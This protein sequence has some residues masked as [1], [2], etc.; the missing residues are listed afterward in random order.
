MRAGSGCYA[1]TSRTGCGAGSPQ[2]ASGLLHAD[3]QG[4]AAGRPRSSFAVPCSRA[5]TRAMPVWRSTGRITDYWLFGYRLG[6]GGRSS[7]GRPAF[8]SG[9]SAFLRPG[10]VWAQHHGLQLGER[11][12]HVRAADPA[13]A[14]VGA[15]AAAE[16]EVRL[17]VVARLVDVDPPRV[18]PVG[19]LESV[20]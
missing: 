18:D 17:P 1:L 15:G 2:P 8:F 14:A 7:G 9:R 13:D 16:R 20:L 11:L 5:S 3:V 6:L 10:Y 4:R 19:E 12:H